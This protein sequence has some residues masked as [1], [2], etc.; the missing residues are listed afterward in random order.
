MIEDD[1]NYV[2]NDEGDGQEEQ[3]E[4]E[5]PFSLAQPYGARASTCGYCGPPGARS[6]ARSSFTFGLD[7]VQ[8]SCMVRFAGESAFLLLGLFFAFIAR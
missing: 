5:E 3:E 1:D 8:L 2:N 6:F 7:A 4:E